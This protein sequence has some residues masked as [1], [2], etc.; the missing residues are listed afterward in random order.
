[1]SAAA[2]TADA[3]PKK[4]GSKKMII[5]IAVVALL[6]LGGG[7]A[8]FV[9]M[10]QKAAAAAAAAEEEGGE[11]GGAHAAPAPKAHKKSD[12]AHPP[13][14]VPLDPFTVNLADRDKDRY[15]QI[16]VT[17]EIDDA[18][19]ADELKAYMP[20][21]RN[22]VLMVLAHKTS[23]E[24]LER[25][26]KEKLAR[27]IRREASRPLGIELDDEEEEDDEEAA[28]TR[29]KKKKKKPAP[30]HSPVTQVHFANFIIQ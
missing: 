12:P 15:A 23:A 5:I 2:A 16:A 21:I 3:E 11:D 29:K 9:I 27:E 8:A 19:V 26:G 4:K 24:L 30:V 14:F 17:L 22:G 20:V 18:K 10:K 25:E 1:M 7:G 6:V 28:P 13:T